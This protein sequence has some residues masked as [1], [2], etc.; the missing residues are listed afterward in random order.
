MA[1]GERQLPAAARFC[2]IIEASHDGRIRE[3]DCWTIARI[4]KLAGAPANVAAG[5]RLLKQVGDIVHKGEPLF[6]IHAQSRDQARFGRDYADGH[7]DLIQF[8]F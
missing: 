8:G 1:Q 6:E 7:A 2:E 5:V 3:I 4:A